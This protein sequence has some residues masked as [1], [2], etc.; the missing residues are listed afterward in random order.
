MSQYEDTSY[1][2]MRQYEDQ[3]LEPTFEERLL[4]ALLVDLREGKT[5][6]Q[7]VFENEWNCPALNGRLTVPGHQDIMVCLRPT[8][9]TTSDWHECHAVV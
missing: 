1:S 7:L 6:D 2:S 9:N 8:R 3:V 4:A 5:S